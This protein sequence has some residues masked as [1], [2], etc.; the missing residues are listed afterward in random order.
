METIRIFIAIVVHL[1]WPIYQL[2]VLTIFLNAIRDEDVFMEQPQGFVKHGEGH[3]VSFTIP[4][5]VYV[6]VLELGM[7]IF[8]LHFSL[9]ISYSQIPIQIFIVLTL[10]LTQ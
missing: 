5:M 2:D 8:M 7:F 3:I 1:N 10:L 4:N 6:K 9:E